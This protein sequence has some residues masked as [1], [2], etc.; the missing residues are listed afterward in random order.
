MPWPPWRPSLHSFWWHGATT[1][2]RAPNLPTSAPPLRESAQRHRLSQ[3]D[4]LRAPWFLDK[5]HV[6][7]LD[8]TRRKIK[9]QQAWEVLR[10][11]VVFEGVSERVSERKSEDLWEDPL[12]WRISHRIHL[13]EVSRE[14]LRDPLRAPLR[15]PLSSELRVL[16]PL[17]VL[18]RDTSPFFR[19]SFV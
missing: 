2:P 15:V 12:C 11:F 19:Y 6:I 10:G 4:C 16:L 7:F 3:N 18:P 9:G 1:K 5:C 8:Y 13:S 17:I 14:P